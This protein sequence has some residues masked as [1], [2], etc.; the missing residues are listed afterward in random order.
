MRDAPDLPLVQWLSSRE[1]ESLFGFIPLDSRMRRDRNSATSTQ[2]TKHHSFALGSESS[3]RVLEATYD[4]PNTPVV[5]TGF[6]PERALPHCRQQ[7]ID[8]DDRVDSR[9]EPKS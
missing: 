2:C 4:A 8:L 9:C 6:D 7:I 1:T 5:L 3:R